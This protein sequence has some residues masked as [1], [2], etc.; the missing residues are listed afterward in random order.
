[1]ES[2][3][4]QPLIC[5]LDA[6]F[7][8]LITI[9]WKKGWVKDDECCCCCCCCCLISFWERP[10]PLARRWDDEWWV[11][12]LWFVWGWG[13]L[14]WIKNIVAA[15]PSAS[16][17]IS[18]LLQKQNFF[19]LENLGLYVSYPR[20][21]SWCGGGMQLINLNCSCYS[22]PPLFVR[23]QYSYHWHRNI[24]QLVS[25]PCILTWYT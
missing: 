13:W 6:C 21:R 1:M 9:W 2:D 19:C 7:V 3:V 20:T 16:R 4:L 8:L 12:G 22:I 25:L 18:N 5:C 11:M 14:G 10:T 23:K 17:A 24:G 15:E